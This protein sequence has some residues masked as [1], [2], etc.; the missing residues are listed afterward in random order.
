MARV[1]R[2]SIISATLVVVGLVVCSATPVGCGPLPQQ[3]E[4]EI[5]QPASWV[6]FEADVFQS[7][8]GIPDWFG[9]F[10]R[11]SD[12]SER[13]DQASR[14]GTVHHVTIVN[15]RTGWQYGC[16][17]HGGWCTRFRFNGS[18]IRPIL[19][20]RVNT[21]DRSATDQQVEGYAVYEYS[22]PSGARTLEAPALN[23]AALVVD[24]PTNGMHR[25]LHN[26]SLREPD[27]SLFEPPRGFAIKD[28]DPKR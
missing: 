18:P 20:R 19:R 9:T 26:I 15:V 4:S 2:L 17:V 5:D 25:E 1:P 23:F 7:A 24:D 16:D 12:G 8:P 27:P 21:I 14:D 11:S 22:P 3:K 28:A 13:Y 6:A 10:H